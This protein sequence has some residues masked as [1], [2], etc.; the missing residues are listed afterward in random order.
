MLFRSQQEVANDFDSFLKTHHNIEH[1]YFNGQKAA[2]YF[3]KYVILDKN[4]QMTTLP[5]TSPA[6]AGKNFDEKLKEWSI[7]QIHLK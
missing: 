4:Y 6:N 5:S 3:K 7:I 2:A 1:I